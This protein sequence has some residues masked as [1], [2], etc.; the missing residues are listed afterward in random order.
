MTLYLLYM[1]VFLFI[2]RISFWC[3]LF[4]HQTWW[5]AKVVK[6]RF[7]FFFF[8]GGELLYN[9]ML[10]SAILFIITLPLDPLSAPS[11]HPCRLLQNARLGSL[12]YK[13]TSPWLWILPMIVHMY[14]CHFPNLSHHFLTL[15]VQKSTH[16]I[17]ISTPS[18]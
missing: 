7:F 3:R 18:L 5:R 17:C 13:A 4:C 8:I 2:T 12:C 10:V 9:V 1:N 16:Y 11:F 6:K 14:Q 15:L